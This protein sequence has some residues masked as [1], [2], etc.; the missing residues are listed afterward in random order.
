MFFNQVDALRKTSYLSHLNLKIELTMSRLKG[1]A[2]A[3][4]HILKTKP[5]A[6]TKN[7]RV[8]P[9][10]LVGS[11][12]LSV[13]IA[14]L[15]GPSDGFFP[16]PPRKP[17]A[18]TLIQNG[19]IQAAYNPAARSNALIDVTPYKSPFSGEQMDLYRDI[20]R[21]Q[22]A[23]SVEDAN[24]I[25][26]RLTDKSLMGHVLAQRYLATS[27]KASF[28]ELKNWLESYADHPQADRIARLANGRTP[29]DYKGGLT[30]ASYTASHIEELEEPGMGAKQYD[31]K[32]KRSD[33]ENDQA[34]DMIRTVRRHIQQYQPSSALRLL[35][36]S[37]TSL[38]LDNVEKDRLKAM[39]AA[40]YFYAGKTAEAEKLAGEALRRSRGAAPM[41]GWIHGLSKW[42]AGEYK[43]AASSFAVAAESHYATGWMVAAASYWTARAHGEAGHKRRM[44]KFLERAA[45][46][47]RTFYG[48]LAIQA[49]GRSADMNWDAPDLGGSDEDDILKTV[50]GERAE[51]LLAAGEVTLAEAEIKSLY[52]KGDA[53]RKKA[54]LAYAYD[55]QLPSLTLKLAH[56]VLPEESP[57]AALYPSMPWSPNQGFRIDRALMHAIVRQES[58]FNAA[59]EN[60]GSGATGLMQLMPRTAGHVAGK[61]IFMNASGRTLLKSPEVSLDLGQEYVEELLNN[62]LVGQDLLALAIAYNAGPGT[63]AKWKAERPDIDDPLL[64]IET[65]PFAET[66]T[67][68][69]RVLANYWIYRMKFDQPNDSMEALAEGRWAR[70]AAYDKGAIKFADAR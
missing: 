47:P 53:P 65:I 32:I 11:L 36:E 19:M 2:A 46:Y 22:A 49:L 51:K 33:D 41:A 42:R 57:D 62:P 28:D 25:I 24:K 27:Y 8:C 43:Q 6:L 5:A 35:N 21:L 30:K 60:K 54:L 64:F 13:T 10:L 58:R 39:I 3:G 56:A 69:E 14:S 68:V 29:K 61:N 70:Y 7:S 38:N 48:L 55:R 17:D 44:N 18:A 4:L 1:F 34:T 26:A 37:N 45:E 52:I 66:R 40:G 31:S 59:A 23:G 15:A 12:A 63:L 20:F 16:M 9:F 67:Y 50:A